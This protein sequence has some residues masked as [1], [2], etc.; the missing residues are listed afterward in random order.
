MD[1][2]ELIE[3]NDGRQCQVDGTWS[4]GWRSRLRK[5]RGHLV[6]RTLEPSEKVPHVID[7][8]LQVVGPVLRKEPRSRKVDKC[9]TVLSQ[10]ASDV[11]IIRARS[12]AETLV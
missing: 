9:G 6:S 1:H 11:P 8:D 12:S 5:N 3:P 7:A 4:S 10:Y 2:K